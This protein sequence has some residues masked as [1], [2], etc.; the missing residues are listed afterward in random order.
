VGH[1]GGVVSVVCYLTA[2]SIRASHVSRR[3]CRHLQ[4]I[5]HRWDQ[6]GLGEEVLVP[7]SEGKVVHAAALCRPIRQIPVLL[8]FGA[9]GAMRIAKLSVLHVG[10]GGIPV[11]HAEVDAHRN[12]FE[13]LQA[14]F[15]QNLQRCLE[16]AHVIVF[17][18]QRPRVL[19]DV[20]GRQERSLMGSHPVEHG[21]D[22]FAQSGSWVVLVS[23]SIHIPSWNNNNNNAAYNALK[24]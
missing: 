18:E 8:A 22:N 20:L 6:V 13:G 16:P 2:P 15:L 24:E 19:P 3:K 4:V 12:D 9:A 7:L 5:F 10:M 21:E 14:M 11:S 23:L 1:V 17:G